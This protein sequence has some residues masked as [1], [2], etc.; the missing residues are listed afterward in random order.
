MT[1]MD[2]DTKE[3]KKDARKEGRKDDARKAGGTDDDA[4]RALSAIAGA[5]AR[6]RDGD[7]AATAIEPD[8]DTPRPRGDLIGSPADAASHAFS[9][10]ARKHAVTA[11]PPAPTAATIGAGTR[12]L[13]NQPKR[14]SLYEQIVES[15]DDLVGFI[16]YALSKQRKRDWHSA[17]AAETG[18]P[19]RDE[20]AY[21][22]LLGEVTDKQMHAYRQNAAN[23]LRNHAESIG[24]SDRTDMRPDAIDRQGKPAGFGWGKLVLAATFGAFFVLIALGALVAL[25]PMLGIDPGFSLTLTTT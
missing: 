7:Q 9:A 20:E 10:I 14:R 17:F 3:P 18:R 8:I 15:D 6:T 16:A 12:A 1:A 11:E 21:A 13:P 23:L 22:F 19:P 2:V 25:L 24:G 5:L 4:S